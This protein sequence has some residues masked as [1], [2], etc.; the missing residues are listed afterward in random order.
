MNAA[1]AWRVAVRPVVEGII[2]D[3]AV[4]GMVIAVEQGDGAPEF[5]AAGTDTAGTQLGADTLFPVA[6]ITKLATAL[7]VLRLVAADELALD[8]PL[9]RY[10]P[11]RHA[12]RQVD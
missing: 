7:A 5:L 8:A 6:S 10:L 9:A 1:Q 2:R 3:D 4:P 12:T 11:K